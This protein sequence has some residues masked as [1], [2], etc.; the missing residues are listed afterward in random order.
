MRMPIN[1]NCRLKTS[2]IAGNSLRRQSAAKILLKGEIIMNNNFSVNKMNEAINLLI[3]FNSD[4]RVDS[5][6]IQFNKG[7]YS[8]NALLIDDKDGKAYRM[9]VTINPEG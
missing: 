9:T 1:K 8:G 4:T 3:N 5:L 6:Q 2:L 7:Y